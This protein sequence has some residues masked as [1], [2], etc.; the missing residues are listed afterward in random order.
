MTYQ[1][2]LEVF[3]GPLDLLLYLIKKEEID[4]YDIPI[5]RIT[6]QYLSYLEMMKELNLELGGEFLVMA[7]TLVHIKSKMLLPKTPV[8]EGD[9]AVEEDPRAPLRDLLLEYQKFKEAA[10]FL[11]DQEK[12]RQRIH[13]RKGGGEETEEEYLEVSLFDLLSA[14]AQLAQRLA[15]QGEESLEVTPDELSIKEKI[16]ELI[17]RLDDKSPLTFEEL[18]GE[19]KSRGHLIITFLA[20]L[21]I[22]RQHLA[23]ARQSRLYGEIM[24]YRGEESS[25][26]GKTTH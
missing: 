5:S 24:I 9:I 19:I 20:L 2:K 6:E 10:V 17:S 16:V 4:I 18:L 7:A 13:I 25:I 1:V 8:E 12:V 14:F 11:E 26:N 15:T 21:E 3:E 23:L 22:I